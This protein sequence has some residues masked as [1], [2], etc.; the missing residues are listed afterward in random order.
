MAFAAVVH[1]NHLV[2]EGIRFFRSGADSVFLG[3]FGEKRIAPRHLEV[4]DQFAVTKLTLLHPTTVEIDFTRARQAGLEANARALRGQGRVDLSASDQQTGKLVLV[5]FEVLGDELARAINADAP[6]L[7]RIR[8]LGRARICHK[9]LVAMDESLAQ[10]YQRSGEVSLAAG[11][12]ES[13]TIT[14]A[15]EGSNT[16]HFSS[17]TTFAYLLAKPRWSGAAIEAL[18][19]DQWGAG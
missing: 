8:Q 3:A 7:A 18:E 10:T 15:S 11:K 19:D 14:A 12:G 9:I 17:G 6:T 4:H 2:L 16:V 5:K 13:A 1:D